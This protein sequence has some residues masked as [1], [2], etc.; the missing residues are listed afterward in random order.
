[1]LNER[2]EDCW[3]RSVDVRKHGVAWRSVQAKEHTRM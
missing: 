2:V 3:D 1:V